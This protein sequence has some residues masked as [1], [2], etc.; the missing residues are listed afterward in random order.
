MSKVTLALLMAAAA[1][2]VAGVFF[3]I[4][5]ISSGSGVLLLVALGYAYVVTRR[6]TELLIAAL[7][8]REQNR[9][10]DS[11]APHYPAQHPAE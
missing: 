11:R 2:I 5:W 1:L 6:E 9:F 4:S 7:R 8:D 10:R 3:E